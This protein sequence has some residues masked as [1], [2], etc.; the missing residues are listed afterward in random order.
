[1]KRIAFGVAV[2][3]AVAIV[4]GLVVSRMAPTRNAPEG[5]VVKTQRDADLA[6]AVIMA[7]R[8][9]PEFIDVFS[10]Q[11]QAGKFAVCAKVETPI[12]PEHLWVRIDGL[13]K[14]EF[15]GRLD[16]EPKAWKEKR[17]G[18]SMTVKKADVVDWMYDLGDGLQGGYTLKALGN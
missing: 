2:I 15:T 13:A 9:L 8:K 12:G 18:D 1:M 16:V 11:G 10:K 7:Q 3:V 17:K 4:L 6:A 14:D 5:G